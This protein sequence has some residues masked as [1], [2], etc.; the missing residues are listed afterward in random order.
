MGSHYNQGQRLREDDFLKNL[1]WR[2]GI[3]YIPQKF[4][5]YKFIMF[6]TVHT[7]SCVVYIVLELQY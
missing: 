4:L 1:R 6:P 3:A 5:K 7:G 2:D